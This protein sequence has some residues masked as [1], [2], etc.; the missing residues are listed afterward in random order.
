MN[1]EEPIRDQAERL[2][3]RIE[4]IENPNNEQQSEI[5]PPRSK[6]HQQKK[7][8]T[9]FKL[10]YPIIR[11]L[12]LFF[13]LLPIVSFSLYTIN[14]NNKSIEPVSNEQQSIEPVDFEEEEETATN[15]TGKEE[16]VSED[17]ASETNNIGVELPEDNGKDS[18]TPSVNDKST[19]NKV[20]GEN[21]DEDS[22]V[23]MKYH[24][25]QPN[26]TL[27]RIAM[28]YYHSQS[29][30]ETIKQANGIRGNEIIVGETLKI[31][32]K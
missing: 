20:T 30:I 19:A 32:M 28:K 11:L 10:K 8:K 23:E 13:I 14:E 17:P 21:K 27:F 25:V 22:S 29:G 16:Q 6:V 2:R 24:K 4:K 1:R 7:K 12:A 9:K 18:S 26:E 15:D 5:L 3:K 31:P